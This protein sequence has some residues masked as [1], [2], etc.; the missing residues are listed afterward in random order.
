MLIQKY[1]DRFW[2]YVN[3]G[4]ADV[5]WPWTGG[6]RTKGYGAYRV[7]RK[8]IAAHRYAMMIHLGHNIPENLH[9]LHTCDVP[10]CC[11]PH[12]L[13]LGTNTDNVN[14]R[15]QR[16]RSHRPIGE[17]SGMSKMTGAHIRALLEKR[18]S[19]TS[20]RA[21]AK[22]YNL[23]RST[24]SAICKGRTWAHIHGTVGTPN[25]GELAAVVTLNT[26]SEPKLTTEDVL[27]LLND[28]LAGADFKALSRKFDIASKTVAQICSG[29]R[30]KHVLSLP[31]APSLESLAAVPK[32]DRGGAILTED[33]ARDIIRRLG[34]GESGK[35]IAREYDV[36]FVTISD[37]KTGRG[38]SHL[39]GTDGL[40]T[41]DQMKNA[42]PQSKFVAKLDETMARDIKRRLSAGEKARSIAESLSLSTGAVYHI[43]NGRTWS[44]L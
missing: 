7:E 11:N 34:N 12:H 22:E 30:Y 25:V 43:K 35:S 39:P 29:E 37:I 19:G 42:K 36:H 24:V 33:Q 40:P 41:I 3:A 18:M 44:H 1:I 28:R 10:A 8:P 4:S 38:W 26:A 32:N 6:K 16:K 23:D 2:T 14:D 15:V 17:L 21:L 9:V 27:E 20:I 5:C 31:E 13:K